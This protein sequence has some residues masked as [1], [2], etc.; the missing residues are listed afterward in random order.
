M[1]K[2]FFKLAVL[3][4]IGFNFTSVSESTIS[5]KL[6]ITVSNIKSAEGNIMIAVYDAGQEFLGQEMVTGKVERVTQTGEM[7]IVIDDLPFGEYAISI[8]HDENAN[9]NLDTNFFKL[10]TEPYGFS[11]DARGTFGPPSFEDAKII[12]KSNQREFSI[13]LK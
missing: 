9:E 10:P 13:R 8:Y 2:S 6:L 7:T 12:F 1:K 5:D 4:S 3:L 11:N